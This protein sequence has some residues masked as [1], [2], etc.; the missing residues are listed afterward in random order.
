M[1]SGTGSVFAALTTLED[2][3]DFIAAGY[4]V[5][6][7]RDGPAAAAQEAA[8]FGF[9]LGRLPLA[10]AAPGPLMAHAVALAGP[11]GITLQQ[12]RTLFERMGVD[13]FAQ[14]L[15]QL[16]DGG[17]VVETKERRPNRSGRLQ[18]QVVLRIAVG[19]G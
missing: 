10:V 18:Q 11:H 12:L 2:V 5:A 17:Q 9:E 6:S 15:A 16:R 1:T 8:R 4:A 19:G 7:V 3:R 14:G 13:R